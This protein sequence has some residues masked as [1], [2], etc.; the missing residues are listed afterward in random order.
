MENYIYMCY[1]EKLV[2]F[3]GMIWDNHSN[4]RCISLG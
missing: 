2:I 4:N 1:D 3:I